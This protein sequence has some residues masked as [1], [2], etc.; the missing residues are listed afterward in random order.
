MEE[1][2][3]ARGL[4]TTMGTKGREYNGLIVKSTKNSISPE[5]QHLRSVLQCL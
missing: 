4:N 2:K 1:L 3:K 5:E